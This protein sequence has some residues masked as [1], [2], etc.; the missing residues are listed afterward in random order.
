MMRKLKM[1]WEHCNED[2][3]SNTIVCPIVTK[4][5][6]HVVGEKSFVNPSIKPH[7]LISRLIKV[8]SNVETMGPFFVTLLYSSLLT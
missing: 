1:V 3:L 6:G 4:E 5:L 7:I 2:G 8:F